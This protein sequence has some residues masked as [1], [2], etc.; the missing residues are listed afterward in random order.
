M[1]NISFG[2]KNLYHQCNGGP[3][4]TNQ[5]MLDIGVQKRSKAFLKELYI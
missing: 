4:S 3:Y 1:G 2:Q 5:H